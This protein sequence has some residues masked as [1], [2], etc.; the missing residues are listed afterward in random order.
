MNDRQVRLSTGIGV[1]HPA[2]LQRRIHDLL[3]IG[4]AGLVPAALALAIIVET[5]DASIS[6]VALVLAA[7]VAG[8]GIAALV[9]SSRMEVTVTLLAVYLLLLYGPIK[10]G[11]GGGP[12]AHAADDVLILAICTGA[13]M[14]LAVRRERVTLPRDRL[15]LG[16][17]L[18][19]EPGHEVVAG[20]RPRPRPDERVLAVVELVRHEQERRVQDDR[21]RERRL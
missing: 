15:G 12:L 7:I 6:N 3:L 19:V 17:L 4:L 13:L 2:V 1:V 10:L 14:R 20:Q 8:L 21:E 9:A 5:P 16:R 11:F 18:L